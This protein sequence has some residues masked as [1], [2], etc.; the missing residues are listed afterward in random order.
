MAKLASK[1]SPATP[2]PEPVRPTY[3]NPRDFVHVRGQESAKRA[4]LISMAGQHSIVLI[5]PSGAGKSMLIAATKSITLQ[6]VHAKMSEARG[7]PEVTNFDDYTDFD[8]MCEV[9]QVPFG[10]L[11]GQRPGTD[12]GTI[13]RQILAYAKAKPVD[14]SLASVGS[15]GVRTLMKQAYVELNM[16]PRGAVRTLK[17]A[18]TI[19]RLDDRS[20]INESHLAEAI[21]YNIDR[22][23]VMKRIEAHSFDV[24]SANGL[25]TAIDLAA[26]QP[27]DRVAL[28]TIREMVGQLRKMIG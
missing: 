25:L 8:M 19:A 9:P 11:F 21:G 12:T 13:H 16:T 1:A 22:A 6:N 5:G 14:S 23:L 3:I 7:Y 26:S 28:D 20:A 2:A 18:A 15:E 4:L 17:V 24:R 27:R 10:D